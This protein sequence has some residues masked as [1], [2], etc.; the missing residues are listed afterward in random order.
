M[1][2]KVDKFVN[3]DD[4]I[5]VTA[6]KVAIPPPCACFERMDSHCIVLVIQAKVS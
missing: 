1:E 2:W 6:E 4:V 3:V 5:L